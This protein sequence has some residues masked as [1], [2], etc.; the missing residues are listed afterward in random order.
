MGQ[1]VAQLERLVAEGEMERI[2]MNVMNGLGVGDTRR[3][4]VFR[5]VGVVSGNAGKVLDGC[6]RSWIDVEV[7]F[8]AIWILTSKG[9]VLVCVQFNADGGYTFGATC[10]STRQRFCEVFLVGFD[11]ISM[12]SR[13]ASFLAM[14][15][16]LCFA[17]SLIYPVSCALCFALSVGKKQRML[18]CSLFAFVSLAK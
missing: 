1:A 6:A 7:K 12:G 14:C 16:T 11:P 13:R 15:E 4:G 5:V 10:T 17:I 3:S 18:S 2:G 8:K 9:T